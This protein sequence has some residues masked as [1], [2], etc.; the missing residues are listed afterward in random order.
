MSLLLNVLSHFRF[1]ALCL[2]LSRLCRRCI[3]RVFGSP[4]QTSRR[5]SA[6]LLEL[7][8]TTAPQKQCARLLPATQSNLL[9]RHSSNKWQAPEGL[10]KAKE[11]ENDAEI[12]SGSGIEIEMF[13]HQLRNTSRARLRAKAHDEGARRQRQGFMGIVCWLLGLV[14]ARLG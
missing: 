5:E 9:L 7:A 4:T 8:G 11:R 3:A 6:C 13:L 12:E 2:S 1:V 14:A 10:K